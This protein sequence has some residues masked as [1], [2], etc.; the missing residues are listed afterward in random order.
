MSRTESL[1]AACVNEHGGRGRWVLHPPNQR[2]PPMTM[3]GREGCAPRHL[4]SSSLVCDQQE[5]EVV[6]LPNG[7]WHETCGLEGY[8]IGIGGITYH[9][10]HSI[11]PEGEE[12]SGPCDEDD[13]YAIRDI[14][15]CETHLCPSL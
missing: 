5:G 10:A 1:Q 11:G 7:W 8:S 14:P 6:W 13:E 15:Y 9:G 3:R 4:S 2:I 12:T